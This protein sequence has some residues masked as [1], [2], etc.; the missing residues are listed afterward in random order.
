MACA[1]IGL[2]DDTHAA[3]HRAGGTRFYV[4]CGLATLAKGLLGV[5]LPAVI[6]VALRGARA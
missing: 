6:L 1:I 2:F 5:G 3:P 4:F